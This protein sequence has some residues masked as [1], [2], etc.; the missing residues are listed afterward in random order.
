ML[1]NTKKVVIYSDG[2]CSNNHS[3]ENIGGWGAVLIF[4][5][6]TKEIYGSAINTTN[7]VMELTA[8]IKALNILKTDKYPVELYTDSAYIVNC[9]SEKWY[10]KWQKNNWINSKKEPVSNK[11][12]WEE[13]IQL[14][15]KY[16]VKFIKVKGHS[17]VELNERADALVQ[18]G[19]TELKNSLK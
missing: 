19:I 6:K 17:G 1:K 2:G 18:K 16:N 8:C 5:D 11:E 3:K 14:S 15:E 13:L 10:V 12:L 7:N 9:F 4:N